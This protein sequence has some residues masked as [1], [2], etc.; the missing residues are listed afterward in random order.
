M[1]ID[2]D[3]VD[4]VPIPIAI[5]FCGLFPVA[6]GP[7]PAVIATAYTYIETIYSL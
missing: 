3:I 4:V 6:C 2:I 5:A 1:Y 7:V